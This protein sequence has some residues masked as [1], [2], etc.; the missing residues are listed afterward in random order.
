MC[1]FS[2]RLILVYDGNPILYKAMVEG[3][4]SYFHEDART[5]GD[6]DKITLIYV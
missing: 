6:S 1:C 3:N 2:H 5:V 4:I